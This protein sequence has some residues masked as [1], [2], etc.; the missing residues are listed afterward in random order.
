[1]PIEALEVGRFH[2]NEA[3]EI[4]IGETQLTDPHLSSLNLREHLES[5]LYFN[6]LG[7]GFVKPTDLLFLDTETT[8]LAGGTGTHAFLVG[9][10][11]FDASG[12]NLRQFFMRSPA[13]ERALLEELRMFFDEFSVL[14]TFNGKS[15]D[16]PLIDT[17][18]VMHGYRIAFGFSHLDLLHPARR[19]WKHRLPSCSLTS[20]EQ[21]IYRVQRNGDVPGFLIPQLYF[22]YLRDGDARRLSPVFA[23]NRADIVTL[24]RLLETLLA[25]EADPERELTHPEDRIGMGLAFLAAGDL[26]RGYESLTLALESP[27]LEP[28]LRRRAQAEIWQM[29]RREGRMLEGLAM[30]EEMCGSS[31]RS[32]VFD[33]FPFIELAKYYEHVARDYVAA[34][35]VVE[36]ALRLVE[37]RHQVGSRSE[38]TYRLQRIQRKLLASR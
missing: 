23:H 6:Q 5:P 25:V 9:V 3:G 38:L 15:F 2:R 32:G 4:F 31:S 26:Q 24:A 20:L 36:R 12:F 8:G 27:Y 30:L 35:R 14:V 11:Y 33:L 13:E 16:W 34:A 18:F 17:R 21:A 22:D 7:A 10:G 19:I 28:S 29:L 37:L 1:M